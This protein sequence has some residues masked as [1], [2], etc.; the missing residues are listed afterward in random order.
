MNQINGIFFPGGGADLIV[1]I[2]GY[3]NNQTESKDH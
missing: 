3:Q 1:P 2:N